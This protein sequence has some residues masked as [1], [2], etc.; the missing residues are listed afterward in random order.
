MNGLVGIEVLTAMV[1]D[2][3]I[4]WDITPFGPVEVNRRFGETYC[5][6]LQ[7]RK[8]SQISNQQRAE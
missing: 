6:Q 4:F 2:S 7:G 8:V 5:L 3:F 1:V